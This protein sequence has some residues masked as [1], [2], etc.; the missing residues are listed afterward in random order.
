MY[1]N[2]SAASDPWASDVAWIK[3]DT[4]MWIHGKTNFETPPTILD[5]EGFTT[6]QR[7]FFVRQHSEVPRVV[8]DGGDPDDHTFFVEQV[9]HDESGEKS[10]TLKTITFTLGYLKQNFQK[11]SF[12]SMLSCSG[13]RRYEM[14][15]VER[16]GGAISWHNAV[17]NATWGGVLLR[18]VL[19][20]F[21]VSTD[22]TISKYVEFHGKEG[23]R[24]AVPFRKAMDPYGDCLLC[25]EMNG[26]PLEPDHGQPLR[27]LVPGYSAKCSCKWLTGISVRDKDCDHG[28]HK[29]YYKLFPASM[30]PGSDEYTKYHQDPQYTLGELN[31]NSVI[32]EPHSCS[33]AGPPGPLRV[34]GYAHTGGGRALARIEISGNGGRTWEQVRPLQ[35][36]LN[37]AGQLWAWVRYEHVLSDFDTSAP[38]AE[39]V[40]RAWDCA[41]NTQ[42]DWPQWNYT[43]MLNNH[44]YRVKIMESD[45]G[46]VFVH[47]AQWMD[48]TFK[49][50]PVE[51]QK[52]VTFDDMRTTILSG[53]WSIGNF[54][55]ATIFLQADDAGSKLTSKEARW[56]GTLDAQICRGPDGEIEV[57]A[58]FFSFY[59]SGKVMCSDG[60]YTIQWANGMCW[61]KLGTCELDA[62]VQ[63]HR[64]T[65]A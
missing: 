9:I 35:Q 52:P 49:P 27:I 16:T 28:K 19:I 23:Y 2:P 7:L 62:L 1:S 3:R 14:N 15:H 50:R 47:P 32:F 31:V 65:G 20:H 13:Q 48:P 22:H 33:V 17:G 53:Y 21:G 5:R 41:A 59:I 51:V 26:D 64:S 34:T 46:K 58:E 6:P 61:R 4:Q 18:D 45:A 10:R 57:A 54:Q 25:W 42:P 55:N 12:S 38:N 30:R 63:L 24:S 37:E 56:N 44:L 29:A 43:G 60:R 39:I 40:V 11:K 36:E 8:P